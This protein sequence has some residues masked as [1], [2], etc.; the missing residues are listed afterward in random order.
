MFKV[1]LTIINMKSTKKKRQIQIK[2]TILIISDEYLLKMVYK[3][4]I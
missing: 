2:T 1:L 4:I 3:I